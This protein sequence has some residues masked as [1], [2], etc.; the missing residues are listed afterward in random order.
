MLCVALGKYMGAS[1]YDLGQSRVGMRKKLRSQ[2]LCDRSGSEDT[3]RSREDHR[4]CGQEA[5]ILVR[6]GKPMA[7]DLVL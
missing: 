4:G 1:I 7:S 5:R 6:H 2:Q 3:K